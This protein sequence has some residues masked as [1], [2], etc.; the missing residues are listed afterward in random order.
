MKD[1]NC[2]TELYRLGNKTLMFLRDTG[3]CSFLERTYDSKNEVINYKEVLVPEEALDESTQIPTSCEMTMEGR[4]KLLFGNY[5]GMDHFIQFCDEQ[6]IETMTLF[7][8]S[9]CKHD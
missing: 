7:H 1:E 5:D 8:E 3:T 4:M 2:Y 9:S 6:G